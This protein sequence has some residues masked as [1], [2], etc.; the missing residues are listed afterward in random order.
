MGP[1]RQRESVQGKGKGKWREHLDP[2]PPV[3]WR[4]P[5]GLVGD[6]HLKAQEAALRGSGALSP[7]P[8]LWY[9]GTDIYLQG[10][11]GPLQ[12]VGDANR[13]CQP[14]TAMQPGVMLTPRRPTSW[15]WALG[16]ISARKGLGHFDERL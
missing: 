12:H 6:G 4:R 9:M 7:S 8:V 11:R 13:R 5:W 3:W 10:Q 16:T 1:R 14:Q 15:G 2:W